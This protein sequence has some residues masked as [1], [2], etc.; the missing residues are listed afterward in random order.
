MPPYQHLLGQKL[1]QPGVL[2]LKRLQPLRLRHIHAAELGLP[3]VERRV[4]NPV[5]AAQV[6]DLRARLLFPQ[7]PDDLLF[8]KSLPLHPSVL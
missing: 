2:V 7:H 1:L 6:G 5:P 4:R 8:R 3:V